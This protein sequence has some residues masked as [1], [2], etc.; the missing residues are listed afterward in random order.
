MYSKAK[1]VGFIGLTPP[2]MDTLRAYPLVLS[3]QPSRIYW[4]F[5]KLASI[6]KPSFSIYSCI[7]HSDKF[8]IG[9]GGRFIFVNIPPLEEEGYYTYYLKTQRILGLLTCG[10]VPTTRKE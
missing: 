2:A 5:L 3:T 10:K 6:I 9:H 4:T 1:T 8:S 7:K